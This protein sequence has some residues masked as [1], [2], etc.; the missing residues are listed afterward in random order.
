MNYDG[1]RERLKAQ[2]IAKEIVIDNSPANNEFEK[3]FVSQDELYLGTNEFF[4]Y[5]SAPSQLNTNGYL[6][7]W[8][9]D[10]ISDEIVTTEFV[11]LPKIWKSFS[12]EFYWKIETAATGD[13]SWELSTVYVTDQGNL[14]SMPI[15]S[16]ITLVDTAVGVN[17]LKTV[18][19]IPAITVPIAKLFR[20]RMR[21]NASL[22]SDTLTVD[23]L[24]IGMKLRR[25]T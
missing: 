3:G 25:V 24:F 19:I 7:A 1:Y 15:Q 6:R 23:A 9:L 14:A 22:A 17:I 18:A 21:R 8:A 13:V 20:F 5:A 2:N 16:V 11:L 4:A 10:P 12:V